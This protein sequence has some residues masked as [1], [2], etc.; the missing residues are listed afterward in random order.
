[1]GVRTED[2]LHD[3]VLVLVRDRRLEGVLD[4]RC[5]L[6]GC[7]N[8]DSLRGRT[9][10]LA[11]GLT[12]LSRPRYA[13]GHLR[14]APWLSSLLAD[15]GETRPSFGSFMVQCTVNRLAC[16]HPWRLVL[17]IPGQ[18]ARLVCLTGQRKSILL[19]SLLRWLRVLLLILRLVVVPSH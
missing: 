17:H 10:C 16:G 1:M 3:F 7:T 4:L 13:R 18:Q 5:A 11:L 6:V 9:T 19:T 14:T 12:E 2:L 15:W 8:L